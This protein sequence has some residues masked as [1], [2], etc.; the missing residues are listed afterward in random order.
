MIPQAMPED[1]KYMKLALT[2]A[3]KGR[4]TTSPNPMVG[5]VVVKN[6][7][8]VGKGYHRR[9]G[10]PHAEVN[11]LKDSGRNA[12]G[13]TLYV[14]LEPCC[15]A[16][17]TPP[18]VDLIVAKGVGKVV[19]ATRDPNPLNNGRGIRLLRS[20]GI[21][22]KVGTLK[23]EAKRINEVFFKFIAKGLPFVIVK[24]A[25]TLDGK[26]A[27]ITGDSKWITGEAA[28]RYVHRLR[29]QVD[30]I[31]VGV[32]TILR[33]D[34]LLT[35]RLPRHRSINHAPI[36]VIVDS[37]L[38]VP[39]TSRIFSDRSPA[40][41]I[42]A[43][44]RFAYK[45]RIK[46]LE[47]KGAR[48]LVTKDKDGRVQLKSLVK[49]L[50]RFDITSLLVEGGGSVIA[51]ALQGRIVDKVLFFIAPKIVGGKYALTSVEGA[52]IKKIDRAIRLRD[53]AIRRF[54]SDILIEGYP[55]YK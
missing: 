29:S 55:I 46:E 38:K 53:V 34:P 6:G 33:D 52:G 7:K 23:D 20:R 50:A 18:C 4:G 24:I 5:A 54:G 47:A 17:K 22:V 49:E 27:T 30:A 26:I 13:S 10:G 39:P 12:F 25:Q 48:V 44:T 40:P 45:N 31:M 9:A 37:R 1:E 36:K 14:A 21:E 43:T 32:K 42:I 41:T 51:S 35:S 3:L 16:G 11:A 28:R 8:V 19:V 2:L 15:L